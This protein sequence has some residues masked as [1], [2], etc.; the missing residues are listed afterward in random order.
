MR[1][2]KEEGEEEYCD[3]RV[4]L[5]NLGLIFGVYNL[6]DKFDDTTCR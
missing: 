5:T 3:L 1:E 6:Q 2:L 4:V